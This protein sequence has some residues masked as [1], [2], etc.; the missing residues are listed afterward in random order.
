MVEVSLSNVLFW[1]VVFM[2]VPWILIIVWLIV[3][4]VYLAKD[5]G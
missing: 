2:G 4:K 3:Y 5:G 1:W